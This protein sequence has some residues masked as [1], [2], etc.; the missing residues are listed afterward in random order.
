[1]NK[2][3][4][5]ALLGLFSVAACAFFVKESYVITGTV[6]DQSMH[7]LEGVLVSEVGTDNETKTDA[8][9]SYNIS[10]GKAKAT[11]R[12]IYVGYQSEEVR[13]SNS[14]L[15]QDVVL[16]KL[17]NRLQDVLS[18]P[19]SKSLYTP[20][21]GQTVTASNSGQ[22]Q[23]RQDY[24]K[25][26]SEPVP[27]P[28]REGYDGIVENRFRKVTDNPLSTFSI[29]VDGAAYSNIRRF[30]KNGSLPPAGAV[31]IEELINYFH[32]D[33]PQPT[34][35]HPFSINT[36]ISDC[37]WNTS[38]KL[39]LVGLQGKKIPAE[40][41]PASNLV[42][43]VDVSG[44]MDD[45]NKLPLV[46]AAMKLLAE[47]LR[48]EDR[49]AIVVYAGNAGIVLPPVSGNE[50]EMINKALDNLK[51]GGSTAGGA[52]IE[53][54]YKT[55]KEYFKENGNNRVILCTDG[56][57]NVGAS[58]DDEL[59]R[60]IEKERESGIYLSVLGFGMG[61]YQDAKMQKL[62]NKGNGNHSYIDDLN[63]AK[64]VLVTEFGG[65]L[66]T[67]A[68]DVKLQVEFN[69]AKV[70]AYR[71]IGYENRMLNKEDFNNDKKDAGELGS[72]HTVTAL[73]ELIPVGVKNNFAEDVDALKYQAPAK[74]ES[75]TQELMT[76]KFRYKKPKEDKSNLLVRAVHDA[77]TPL[78]QASNNLRFAASVA[79]FGLLVRDSEFKQNASFQNVIETAKS[80]KGTDAEGYRADFIKLV[81]NARLLSKA[82][83]RESDVG[84]R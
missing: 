49:V 55:A 34:D 6:T 62:A 50:K 67:I 26:E 2:I 43:L 61:N 47:Q 25:S 59:E 65:T 63:E 32:Y 21:I 33:Y 53:L 37:P 27:T 24:A 4:L 16:K 13:V 45:A 39:A 20:L 56:D 46:K 69:P 1:M 40:N 82:N 71:L 74:M 23:E 18:S 54:A 84:V 19:R 64:K 30:I 83:G 81:E 22:Y 31:R 41:L 77:N 8:A 15:T 78:N 38:H 28:S 17:S 58:S 75:N 80:A 51:A 73:Y 9:G 42:F 76:I 66:F 70:Q 48:K 14:S 57:F 12:F 11:I 7:P 72:G 36:E 29:D 5:L 10:I 52:G 79:E 3:I 44:S 68:K 35:G 60:M